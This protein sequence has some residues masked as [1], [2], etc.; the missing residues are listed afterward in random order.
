M[1]A[2]LAAAT[3]GVQV[4]AA[5]VATRWVA[6]DIGPATLTLLRYAIGAASLL[7]VV[8]WTGWTAPPPADRP[9]IALLGIGQFG[10]LVALLTLGLQRLPAAHGAV[11]FALFPLLTL[12]FATALGRERPSLRVVAGVVLSILGVALALADKLDLA[13]DQQRTAWI[14][15]GFVLASAATGA[16]CSVLYR[17]YLSRTPALSIGL[18]A[19]MATVAALA[20]PAWWEVAH[21]PPTITAGGWLA[22]V[23]IGLSSG[24]AYW[25][26]LWALA[27]APPTRVTVFLGLGPVTAAALGALLLGEPAGPW[28][29]AGTALV[30]AGQVLTAFSRR[31]HA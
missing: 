12:V 19:M 18:I 2:A 25:L 29:L 16:L 8:W 3:V 11:V 13:A 14:G 6:G 21:Q 10:V 17:P 15:A 9:A 28:L 31:T 23:F 30:V 5:M 7:P 27:H 20:V 4:G 1:R 24:G 26:W 22:V